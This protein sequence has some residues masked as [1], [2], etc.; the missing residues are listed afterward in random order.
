[1]TTAT[2]SPLALSGTL[3]PKLSRWLWLVKMILAI[4]HFVALVALWVWLVITTPIAGAAILITGRYPR[5]LFDLNVRVL[6]W[7][8]RVGFYVYAALGTDKYPPFTLGRADYPAA[9][10]VA[11]PGRLSRGLVLI[12]WMLAIPQLIIVGLLGAD[13]LMYPIAAINDMNTG[14]LAVGGYSV[15]NL[16]VVVAGFLLLV[17]GRYPRSYFDFL[18][19]INRWMYRVIIYLALMTDDYPP[20]RLDSGPTESAVDPRI[21]DQLPAIAH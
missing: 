18:M 11:Y 12:K 16:L 21:I 3:A 6:R 9:L 8:W 17:T 7:N 4:P 15:F 10:E 1:M 19:G 20:F 5:R 13:L 2:G 14:P